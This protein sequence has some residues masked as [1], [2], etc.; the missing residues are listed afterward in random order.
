MRRQAFVVAAGK[1]V[2]ELGYAE[3]SVNRIATEAG[4]PVGLYYRYFRN[5]TDAV[6]AAIETHLEEYSVQVSTLDDSTSFFESQVAGFSLFERLFRAHPGLLSCYYSYDYGEP[7]FAA[8]FHSRTL[9][10]DHL[11][12]QR[13]ARLLKLKGD[14]EPLL[15]VAH[16]LVTM[17]DNVVFRLCTGRDELAQLAIVSDVRVDELVAALRHRL[18]TLSDAPQA[19]P[20]LASLT[21]RRRKKNLQSM[22]PVDFDVLFKR[23]PKRADSTETLESVLATT[24][25][26]LNRH[27]VDDMRIKDVEDQAQITR[28]VIYHYFNEKHDLAW[29]A[30]SG[31]LEALLAALRALHAHPNKTD[32][33]REIVA[34][35]VREYALNPG[36][37]R[38]VYQFEV[39][40][41]ESVKL[42]QFRAA[43]ARMIGELLLEQ[44][45]EED[46]TPIVATMCAYIMLA[47][48]DRFSY[49]LY[50]TPFPEIRARFTDPDSVIDFIATLFARM[51]FRRNPPRKTAH[52]IVSRLPGR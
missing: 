31:R 52:A 39:G 23:Q 44:M 47:T 38:T 41:D 12:L 11:H 7:A 14:L 25:G 29:A 4:A 2:D 1:V 49:D 15:P 26:L 51:L 21:G 50:A 16:L 6:L 27:S 10:F 43:V 5:K 28:G 22:P 35:F 9:S 42:R 24:L 46:R 18:Y 37:L 34:I 13:S 40:C 33:L 8:Y 36:V 20:G 32:T 3:L 45:A 48:I 17:V 19:A 30:I